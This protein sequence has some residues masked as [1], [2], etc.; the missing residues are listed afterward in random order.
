MVGET[1]ETPETFAETLGKVS[2]SARDKGA[3]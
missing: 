1:P 2:K 3:K